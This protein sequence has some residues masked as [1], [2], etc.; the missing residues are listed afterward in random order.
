MSD[1]D[2]IYFGVPASGEH[3]NNC[4]S[5]HPT[6]PCDCRATAE[7]R[8]RVLEDEVAARGKTIGR[9]RTALQK[10][11]A[12]PWGAETSEPW[13]KAEALVALGWPW[14]TGAGSS[15]AGDTT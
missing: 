11:A 13:S 6:N 15:P 9:Y 10:I 5:W 12:G 4:A 3:D 8:V 7:H 1:E 14:P 2:T